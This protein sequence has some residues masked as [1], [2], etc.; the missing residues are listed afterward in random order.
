VK[1]L[2]LVREEAYR[3]GVPL[4]LGALAEQRFLEASARGLGDADMAV[5]VQLYEEA[6]GQSLVAGAVSQTS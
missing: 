3:A 4:L 1:D 2:G 5:L 6:A